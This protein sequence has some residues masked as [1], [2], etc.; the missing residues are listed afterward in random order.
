[1]SSRSLGANDAI[2]AEPAGTGTGR[3]RDPL[4][5]EVRLLGSLLGQVIAE[6]AGRELL[7]LVERVRRTTIQ[8]RRSDD[9]S[10]RAGLVAEL[11]ALDPERAEIVIRAFSLYFRLV[12]LAEER[13]LVRSARRA[14]RERGRQ[15]AA[16]DSSLAAAVEWLRGGGAT[17]P[18]VVAAVSRLRITPVL[19]AHPTEA[20]RRTVLIAL[21]RVDRLLRRLAD[22]DIP[23]AEDRDARRRLREE[24]TLLWRTADLRATA[25]SP[26]DEIR[27]ALAF[28]DE[29]IFTVVP[30]LYREADAALDPQRGSSTR[31]RSRTTRF[32]G[33]EATD[34]GSS[35]T[36]P[37]LAPPFLR[38]ESW[39]GGDR[40]GNPSVT[41][42]VTDR[43]L[44]I[45]ADHVLRGYEAVAARLSQTIAA[46][47]PPDTVPR[48][49]VTRLARDAELLPDLDRQLRRRF[50]DEPYRQRFGFIAERL[51]RTRAHLTGQPAPLTGRYGDADELDVEL[52]EVQE[53]L[54]ADGL[55]RVAWGEVA[56][57]RWQLASFGFHLAA[58]EVRQHSAVH[59]AAEAEL[60]A[61]TAEHEAAPG[62][63]AREVVDT[64]RT[65]ASLQARFGPSAA[66]R[67]VISFTAEAG[68]VA[69]VLGLAKQA[70]EP[71]PVLD[72]VPLFEDATTLEAA[73]EVLGAILS[74]P[75][76]REHLRRRDN[77]QEVM[78]G[79]SDSNKESGYLAANWLLH[80]AQATLSATARTHGV[81][82]TLFHGRGGAIGRGGGPAN[83]GIL[84]LAAG[85]L[86]GRLKLTEQGEV[87]AA[88]YAD[89]GIALRH[90]EGLA[91]ATLVASS[92]AHAATLSSA[93]AVGTPILT[94]LAATSRAAYRELVD[95]PGFVDFF[96]LV[97]PI[98]EIAT[99]RLGS[100][101]ASRGRQGGAP[102]TPV[103]Q[104][105]RSI[106]DLR[107]I[108]WVFAW[109]QA[110]IELPGWFGLGSAIDAYAASRGE[111]GIAALVRLYPRWPFLAS[112]LDNA[113]LALARA[114]LGVGRQYAA[115]AGDAGA[116][117][118]A[119][120]EAEYAR[121]AAWLGRLTGR[122][123]LLDDQ[124]ELRRRLGLRDPY[125]DSLS[126]MQVTLLARLRACEATDPARER[127]LRLVQ[128][129]VNGIAA[130][131][132]RT[133]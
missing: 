35:G 129:T 82:L 36:R 107:A 44:R 124:P 60:A 43:T 115:L 67:Y 117:R 31:A 71:S 12:N 103:Q 53:A 120:I 32:V 37:P 130:G 5:L 42:E 131:L 97:T 98:D 28:F 39:I 91:A 69:R 61:G 109:S 81:E 86:E 89:R 102:A 112:V 33:G 93:E 40:D 1:M 106:A 6:Q 118:W 58:L 132:Q 2:R 64:L 62:V 119:A 110:R 80:R 77:R 75:D 122:D 34:A 27:T 47:T 18:E 57:L 111:A 11:A 68:D 41:S 96:R 7:D 15:P 46:A 70:G 56:D 19:T 4:A 73:G 50:P 113:E 10:L 29:T 104:A 26:L 23:A 105:T 114:D 92:A 45:H 24:I 84:G 63:S 9:S 22:R 66:G 88:N 128:L 125:I 94:E 116:S 87:I 78:L 21:R 76:Y 49:L 52:A 30:R 65:I 83:R 38:W 133:G 13:E 3:A 25:V 72:I 16:P 48:A 85:A 14:E 17:E 59:R 123:R 126:E 99:L 95:A 55:A 8:L 74:D 127:L 20:R 101:P 51:R 90:L 79:Y 108:P 54:V 100:R 121:T